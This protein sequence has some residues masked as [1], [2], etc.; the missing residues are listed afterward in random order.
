MA[1]PHGLVRARSRVVLATGV[2]LFVLLV[3]KM[4]SKSSLFM[5]VTVA[6]PASHSAAAQPVIVG[7]VDVGWY[8]SS[9]TAFNDLTAVVDGAGV[10]KFTFDP[11]GEW[12]DDGYNWCNMPHVR[13]QDY[14]Q[15]STDF[16][17][18]Y[19]E[20]IQR[21]H[22]RT[23]YASNAFP[24]EPYNWNCDDQGLF[25]YGQSFQPSSSPP[26]KVYWKNTISPVNPFVPSGW[27]GTCQFP[28]I[29]AG[30]LDDSWKH[31]KDVYEVYGELLGFLPNKDEGNGWRDK[32]RYRVTQNVITSQVSGSLIAGAWGEDTTVNP[33][34]VTIQAAN[35]DSL[36][37][38]YPCPAASNAFN[39]I[40]S[41]SNRA[42][43]DHLTAAAPLYATLDSISGVPPNDAGFHKSLDHYFDNLSARQ[44]HAKPFP[45][46]IG[47]EGRCVTQELA[48]Q[49]Y[50]FG[51]WEYA[52]I[53]RGSSASLDASVASIGVW[54]AELAANL[55]EASEGNGTVLMRH[56]VAHDG[57]ISR[58]LSVLQLDEMLWPGMGS[59][60]VFELWRKKTDKSL[61]VR[62]LFGGRVLR[63]ASPTL[64]RMEMLPLDTVLAYFGGLVGVNAGKILAKC[65][66]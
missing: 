51:H 66:T 61:Y 23:P 31:G 32:V 7:G 14:M 52:H 46:K 36:E 12:Q 42:W 37:P 18:Q 55:R 27:I 34:G 50:R 8:P 56:N 63:S 20:I 1:I 48:D 25:F 43:V 3:A 4:R 60:I 38:Q 15:P 9:Q 54:I 35:I 45:C 44:C 40:Q 64:G 13:A 28:Q 53:Y 47:D 22:K 65:R 19:V 5:T 17:L 21:H 30:G 26:A 57:S 6:G 24:V 2:L 33:V 62:A 41:S 29:T 39:A 49:V 11:S 59:E 10:P 58:V 16:E